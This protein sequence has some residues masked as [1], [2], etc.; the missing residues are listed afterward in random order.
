MG[1]LKVM[2]SLEIWSVFPEESE[3]DKH[4]PTS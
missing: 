2:I 3:E 4:F 1:G